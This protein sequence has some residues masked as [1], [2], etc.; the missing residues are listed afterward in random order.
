[1]SSPESSTLPVQY[2]LLYCA[3]GAEHAAEAHASA[4]SARQHM[5]DLPI[6]VVT[7]QQGIE[8]EGLWEV[9]VISADRYHRGC[10]LEVL[11]NSPFERTL[12]LDTDTR[13]LDGL[14]EVFTL[15]DRFDVAM[16]PAPFIRPPK[17][18]QDGA[19]EVF[20]QFNGG[21]LAYR[22]SPAVTAF[23]EHWAALYAKDLAQGEDLLKKGG[24]KTHFPAN[25]PSL[26]QSLWEC[27]ELK[28][29]SLHPRYN[30]RVVIPMVMEGK[31]KVLHAD[32]KAL[33]AAAKVVNKRLGVRI[34]SYA[35][36]RFRMRGG[37]SG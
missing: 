21:F 36:G 20:P 11:R 12:L 27:K 7:D 35:R 14:E 37:K 34:C 25:Q 28:I 2:G 1:M 32:P 6:R 4:V 26:R 17:F 31:V 9:E 15:L 3:F 10:N 23:F 29:F 13:I 19:P 33:D 22:R 5:P 18:R 24:R 16:V 30:Y 8:E